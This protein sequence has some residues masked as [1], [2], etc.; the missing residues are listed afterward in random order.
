MHTRTNR[1]V[2]QLTDAVLLGCHHAALIAGVP[3]VDP[4][5]TLDRAEAVLPKFFRRHW[6]DFAAAA[7]SD[8]QIA[9]FP[10]G[11]K[12]V[13]IF[14][15]VAVVGVMTP[16]S[17]GLV[18]MRNVGSARCERGAASQRAQQYHSS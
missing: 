17:A 6:R 18:S 2:C 7:G 9:L 12:L 8:G 4:T 13:G 16:G 3:G 15:G 5:A 11:G 1:D 10:T 14:S